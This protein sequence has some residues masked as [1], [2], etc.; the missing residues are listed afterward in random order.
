MSESISNK[1]TDQSARKI[2][3]G[4][5]KVGYD[6]NENKKTVGFYA[7][8]S[9][10]TKDRT[11][12]FAKKKL[13]DIFIYAMTLGKNAGLKQD[14][15]KKSDRRDSIDIEYIATHPEYLWMM[16]SVALEE[17]EKNG[18]EPLK[19][20]DDPREKIL[21]VCEQYANYGIELLI[22]MSEKASVSDPHIGYEEKFEELLNRMKQ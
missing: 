15:T 6:G 19:I 7:R 5:P 20:F 2:S 21:G 11:S 18:E 1:K 8:S 22:D 3:A 16:I 10:A 13:A 14:Y 17:A 12:M 9:G 4:W